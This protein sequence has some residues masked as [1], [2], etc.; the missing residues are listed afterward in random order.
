MASQ[1]SR[2]T[3]VPPTPLPASQQSLKNKQR[4]LPLDKDVTQWRDTPLCSQLASQTFS[5]TDLSSAR[6]TDPAY[7]KVK[8]SGQTDAPQARERVVII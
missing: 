8:P 7:R 5:L 6:K 2:K 4:A 3:C 1:A